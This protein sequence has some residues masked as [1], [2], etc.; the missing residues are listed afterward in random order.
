M[1]GIKFCIHRFVPPPSGLRPPIKGSQATDHQR[2]SLDPPSSP[3]RLLPPTPLPYRTAAKCDHRFA[4]LRVLWHLSNWF[5]FGTVYR[6]AQLFLENRER[7]LVLAVAAPFSPDSSRVKSG[8]IMSNTRFLHASSDRESRLSFSY[9][10]FPLTS[11]FFLSLASECEKGS[12]SHSC[13]FLAFR[14]GAP[15]GTDVSATVPATRG[16]GRGERAK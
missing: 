4:P 5:T 16:R 11:S 2:T 7:L 12:F 1:R 14:V 13:I 6:G 9:A 8:A 10:N 3:K 15:F